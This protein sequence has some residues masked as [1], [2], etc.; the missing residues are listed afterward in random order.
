MKTLLRPLL[1]MAS[2]ALAVPTALAAAPSNATGI[3]VTDNDGSVVVTW[4]VPTDQ[5]ITHYEIYYSRKSILENNGAY[6]DLE[7]TDNVLPFV[8]LKNAPKSGDLYVAVSAVN[9]Q[10]EKSNLT[11]EAHITLS[12]TSA[13]SSSTSVAMSIPMSS[14]ASS[15]AAA[16][17]LQLLSAVPVSGTGILLTFNANVNVPRETAASAFKVTY[18]SGLTL[19]LRKLIVDGR[20]V[21][22]ITEPQLPQMSYVIT[23]SS[24]VVSKTVPPMP[25]SMT[26]NVLG[27]WGFGTAVTGTGSVMPPAPAASGLQMESHKQPNGRYVVTVTWTPPTDAANL[28]GYKVLQSDGKG[29]K[30]GTEQVIPPSAK[31]IVLRDVPAGSFG[32]MVTSI[33]ADGSTGQSVAGTIRLE[34]PKPTGKPLTDSGAATTALAVVL[35]GALAG[36]KYME[37]KKALAA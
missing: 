23:V 4:D 14:A 30:L 9:A 1:L 17:E 24:V 28:A 16:T 33:N 19:G 27:V 21:W 15:A 11:E 22:L 7:T 12:G 35:A 3:L 20:S 37:R 36:W 31:N 6:D 25:M 29:H 8:E 10:N 18:G 13:Q 34:A 32:I 2:F 26:K 5:S